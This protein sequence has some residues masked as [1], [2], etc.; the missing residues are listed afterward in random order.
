MAEKETIYVRLTALKDDLYTEMLYPLQKQRKLTNLIYRLLRAYFENDTVRHIVDTKDNQEL[1]SLGAELE[2]IQAEHTENM[3]RLREHNREHKGSTANIMQ[4]DSLMQEMMGTEKVESKSVEGDTNTVNSPNADNNNMGNAVLEQMQT[5]IAKVTELES[6]IASAPSTTPTPVMMP[7]FYP[8]NM[9]MPQ[10][11]FPPM[12]STSADTVDTSKQEKV[13]V[14][15]TE[16]I[17]VKKTESSDED[18]PK[19]KSRRL[20]SGR[21]KGLL[22]SLLDT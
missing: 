19:P 3:I 6:K 7:Y 21:A 14:A 12:M 2:R 8:P 13:V 1:Q 18:A 4:M 22:D 17:T 9:Q 16:E 20:G 10:G 15:E 11:V 5:L